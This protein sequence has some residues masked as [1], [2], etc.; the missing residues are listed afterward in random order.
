MNKTKIVNLK[1]KKINGEDK[2][3]EKKEKIVE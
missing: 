3:N 2:E 1:K